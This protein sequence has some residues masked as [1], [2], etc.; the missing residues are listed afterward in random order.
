MEGEQLA[1]DV[2][3]RFAATLAL[4]W[5][6]EGQ[7]ACRVIGGRQWCLQ[8]ERSLGSGKWVRKAAILKE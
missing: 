7:A 2:Q 4:I 6:K 3:S 8:S 5:I 1:A